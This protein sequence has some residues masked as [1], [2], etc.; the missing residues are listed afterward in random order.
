M[1]KAVVYYSRSGNSK[2]VADILAQELGVEPIRIVS[3]MNWKGL[4]GYMKAGYYSM[5][6]KT[7]PIRLEGQ[8]ASDDEIILVAPLWAGDVAVEAH[9][10]IEKYNGSNIHMVVLS[11]A[12]EVKNQ[13]RFK[14]VHMIKESKTYDH[15]YLKAM[16]NSI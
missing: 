13:E 12:S 7:V 9:A 6:K 1:S 11:K 8:L 16:V 3:D 2:Q 14:S 5:M 4:F 10:F 15:D